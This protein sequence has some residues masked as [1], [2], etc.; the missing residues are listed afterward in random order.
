MQCMKKHAKMLKKLYLCNHQKYSKPNLIKDISMKKIILTIALLAHCLPAAAS[1]TPTSTYAAL[2]VG[3]LSLL[4]TVGS[5][6]KFAGYNKA[7]STEKQAIHDA[8]KKQN[9]LTLEP[10]N[11]YQELD[12][13]QKESIE[14]RD[15]SAS[16]K[17][18]NALN[19]SV[20]QSH[21]YTPKSQD[22]SR[23]HIISTMKE[24]YLPFLS[25][26]QHQDITSFTD[27][28]DKHDG[29]ICE[30]TTQCECETDGYWNKQEKRRDECHGLRKTYNGLKILLDQK[31]KIAAEKLNKANEEAEHLENL[32]PHYDAI[33]KLENKKWW[34]KTAGISLG[35]ISL[36]TFGY[37]GY[38][39]HTKK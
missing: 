9:K 17:A 18:L 20:M 39:G 34:A 38:Q 27:E 19:Y 4:G 11:F 15:E 8:N 31:D 35:A 28:Y 33:P 5:L 7:I 13:A 26:D 16:I 21:L 6:W 29:R 37:L 10:S 36:A 12:L 14:A 24:S 3:G 25:A 30:Q 2:G 1:G 23:A 22:K 32:K